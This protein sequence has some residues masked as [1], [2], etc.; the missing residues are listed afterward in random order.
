MRRRGWAWR[1]AACTSRNTQSMSLLLLLLMPKPLTLKN[2]SPRSSKAANTCI[3]AFR[4][5]TCDGNA[6]TLHTRHMSGHEPQSG[7]ASPAVD[8]GGGGTCE[9]LR[10]VRA[11]ARQGK[12]SRHCRRIGCDANWIRAAC[13]SS[14]REISNKQLQQAGA[15][16]EDS[17]VTDTCARA[18]ERSAASIATAAARSVSVMP[19]SRRD[20][21]VGRRP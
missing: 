18:N 12:K 13:C 3:L 11:V 15:P 17:S 2:D 14:G 19:N 16:S 1:A 5:S 20:E 4:V 21:C 6:T 8:E 10:G 7:F 9:R